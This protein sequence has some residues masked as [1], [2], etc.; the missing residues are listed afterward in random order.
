MDAHMWNAYHIIS[1]RARSVCYAVR[2]QQFRH[3][4]EVAVNTLSRSTREQLQ[5]MEEI[6]LSQHQIQEAASEALSTMHRSESMQSS[7]PTLE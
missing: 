5:A 3:Q 4:T 6:S 1:N 7:P 2:Q